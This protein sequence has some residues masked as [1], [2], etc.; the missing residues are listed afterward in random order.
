MSF[1]I[2]FYKTHYP[3]YQLFKK[4]YNKILID[5]D[6]ERNYKIDKNGKMV[7]KQ[8]IYEMGINI[9]QWDLY[10]RVLQ[11]FIQNLS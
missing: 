10:S 5:F 1:A 11:Q 8:F 4:Y 7:L 2:L 9:H 6:D 3:I